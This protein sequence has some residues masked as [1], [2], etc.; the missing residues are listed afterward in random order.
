[1]KS[2]M[3]QL[4][5]AAVLVLTFAFGAG[6][7]AASDNT[8]A[9][10]SLT[11]AADGNS[12]V[13]F[14]R[15]SDGTLTPA[16]SVATGG[17]GSGNGLGSQSALTLSRD[18]RWLL[19]VNAGSN[20][21]SVFA[22]R[23]NGLFLADKVASGGVRPISV[24]I[25]KNLVYV[26]NAGDAGNISGFTLSPLGTLSPLAG[27]TRNLSNGGVG[28]APGPAQIAFN[29]Q[30][31]MLVVT[32]KAT[33]LIDTFTVGGDGVASDATTH[34]SSGQT[35]F[36][37]EFTKHGTLVVSEA[38]G[39]AADASAVSSYTLSASSFDVISPSVPTN[40]T[41]ACWLVATKNGK[42]AY[43]TNA[44]S[45]SV[46]SYR[47]NPGNS[48]SLLNSRA[49]E[50]GAGA[51]PTDMALGGKSQFLY[52]LNP[53]TLSIS[54]FAVQADGSLT[55]LTGV[56]GLAAGMVGLAAR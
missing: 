38:F 20:E 26:L 48:L 12:V 4:M 51:H 50:P 46:S 47:V 43:T 39:G 21:I 45:D 41:A 9:V 52:V 36:G 6:S 44:G 56:G 2:K 34:A 27:S 19:A 24:T 3:M 7:A 8:G 29:P 25:N 14:N 31:D 10:Y 5:L 28:A 1:M 11:N 17:L 35:P 13:V 55:L 23:A 54:A 40:Q 37:F 18:N 22:V 33:N 53:A 30:G 16:G 32:E 42:F 15:A 49:G